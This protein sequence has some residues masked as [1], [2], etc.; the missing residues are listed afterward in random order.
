MRHA[1]SCSWGTRQECVRTGCAGADLILR[2]VYHSGMKHCP[3]AGMHF[4]QPLH[5]VNTIGFDWANMCMTAYTLPCRSSALSD[6][7][8]EHIATIMGRVN[9]FTGVAYRDDDTIMGW[10]VLNEPRCCWRYPH[11]VRTIVCRSPSTPA[12]D[13]DNAPLSKLSFHAGACVPAT[14]WLH[15]A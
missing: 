5:A 7:F 11:L 9:S 12:S 6:L 10:N 4:H 2:S 3:F 15:F 8:M 13:K 14:L 1:L